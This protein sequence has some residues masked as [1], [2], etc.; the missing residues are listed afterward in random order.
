MAMK[1]LAILELLR[2]HN[3]A[4]TF[5]T[6]FAGFALAYMVAGGSSVLSAVSEPYYWIAAAIV[7]LVAAGGYAINDYYDISIDAVNKPWRPIPSGRVTPREARILALTLMGT[8]V[9]VAMLVGPLS[10]LYALAAA[11]LLHE[12]S[13]WIKRSGFWGNVVV[14]F[15]SASSIVFGGLVFCE[16]SGRMEALPPV[17]LPAAY[18]FLLV[19]GREIV[20]GIEDYRGDMVGG[21]KSLAVI[22]GPRRAAIIAATVLWLVVAVSPLP[23]VKGWYGL[24]YLILA[25]LVDLIAVYSSVVLL[26]AEDPVAIAEKARRALKIAFAFGGLAFILGLVF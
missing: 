17:L 19:L 7:A 11:V 18:A 4:V 2:L 13:R 26:L 16:A 9:C 6:T 3:V 20:K 25:S 22:L 10:T 1:L 24:G 21:V 5:A 12:Y 15:N 14:A 23:F 8:G